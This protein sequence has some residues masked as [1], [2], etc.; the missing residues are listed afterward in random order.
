MENSFKLRD[1]SLL[2]AAG[3]PVMSTLK[4]Y[5]RL[6]E[7]QGLME[8]WNEMK[9]LLHLSSSKS[10]EHMRPTWRNLLT[11]LRLLQLDDLAEQ[12]MTYLNVVAVSATYCEGQGSVA[13]EG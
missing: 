1:L 3:I 10:V 4:A 6:K 12:L 13:K 11:L 7:K 5:S 2:E 8:P 9:R